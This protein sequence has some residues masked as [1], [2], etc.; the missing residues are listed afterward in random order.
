MTISSCEFSGW[1][2]S[3]GSLLFP[4]AVLGKYTNLSDFDNYF[5]PLDYSEANERVR[6]AIA[7]LLNMCLC[8]DKMD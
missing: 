2:S 5:A 7:L 6:E 3:L 4:S 8:A 1:L